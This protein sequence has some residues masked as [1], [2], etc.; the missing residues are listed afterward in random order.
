[1]LK[2]LKII[3][4]LTC[5]SLIACKPAKNDTQ[6]VNPLKT[7][8]NEDSNSKDTLI[9]DSHYTFNQA[10]A[11]TRAPKEIINQ[12]ELIDVQYYSTD[13]KL[14]KGQILTNKALAND[15]KAIFKF[16]LKSKFAIEHAIPVVKYKW[17]D[18]LS[19]QDNNTYSFC[20]RNESFSKH[21]NGMAID[22]N[23][24]YNPVR[25]KEEY[26]YRSDKPEQ[27]HRDSTVNGTFYASHPV[28]QEFK[29]RGFFWGHDFKAKYDDHHFEK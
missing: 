11:G 16:I 19:M 4:L 18:D 29:N 27:A 15:L 9:I 14:H 7:S 21:A 10:V 2:R 5:F 1:M 6:A 3:C 22:I 17:F 24:F 8:F 20:Y 13:K 28:V 25:W 23:P 26:E 12:L